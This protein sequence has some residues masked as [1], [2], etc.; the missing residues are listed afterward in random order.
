MQFYPNAIKNY[1]PRIS[2]FLDPTLASGVGGKFSWGGGSIHKAKYLVGF[3]F[4][5]TN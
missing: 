2:R 1:I 3:F 5:K 4:I